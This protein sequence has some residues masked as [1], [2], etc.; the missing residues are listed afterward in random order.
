MSGK[1]TSLKLQKR[2]RER[3]NVYL[4]GEFA[5]GLSKLVGGWLEVGQELS[6]EKIRQLAAE[7]EVEAAYQKALH[8]LSYRARAEK[9]IVDK[10][11]KRETSDETIDKVMER[12]QRNKLVDDRDFA[13]L[14]VENR[15]EFRPRG[16]HVLRMEM[17]QKGISEE[18]IEDALE[19]IDEESLAYRAAKKQ[20]RKY[21][22]T[23]WEEFRRKLGAFLARRGFNYDISST[24]VKK[25][26][27]ENRLAAVENNIGPNEVNHER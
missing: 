1:I 13:S 4:D 25:V 17:R 2:N 26:W 20:A 10:L 18:T 23:D 21:R 19:D 27:E 14:W 16:K 22:A 15:S 12:L 5:F 24:T 9:E 3:V 8:F 11:R 7:D 6:D